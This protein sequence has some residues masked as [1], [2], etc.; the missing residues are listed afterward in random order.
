M[1][2]V[3]DTSD[4]TFYNLVF[5]R[6]ENEYNKLVS[7][8]E[9]AITDVVAGGLGPGGGTTT[10]KMI[11]IDGNEVVRKLS[12]AIIVTFE[13]NQTVGLSGD[14]DTKEDELKQDVAEALDLE[15]LKEILETE[16]LQSEYG[17]FTLA[18]IETDLGDGSDQIIETLV[19]NTLLFTFSYCIV[20]NSDCNCT[21]RR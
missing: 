16:E 6:G 2:T 8:L 7:T 9:D 18:K 4:L 13:I 20:I 3:T 5:P 19:R 1:V 21:S 10:T 15:K 14:T 11:A 17:E 12:T